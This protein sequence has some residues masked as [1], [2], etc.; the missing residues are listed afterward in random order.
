LLAG[1]P[2]RAA[3]LWP[4]VAGFRETM[5]A[6]YHE[7]WRLGRVLDRGFPI[8]LGLPADYFGDKLEGPNATLRLLRYPKV[9]APLAA[10][11][12]GAG[13]HTDYGNVTLLATDATGGLMVKDRQGKWLEAPVV[14]VRWSNDAYVS[15]PHKVVSPTTAE[16]YSIA[17]FLIPIRMRSSRACRRA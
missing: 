4:D 14:R 3:N 10:G 1:A 9:T 5:L 7:L 8:D 16:R 11:Q 17:F 15:T 13:V 6:Y 12:L 2:F